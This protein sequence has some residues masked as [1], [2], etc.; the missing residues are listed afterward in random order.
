M[1]APRP[2]VPL[3]LTAVLLVLGMLLAGCG[4]SDTPEDSP[5]QVL[6]AAKKQLDTTSGVRIGLSTPKLPTGVDGLLSATGIG[7]HAPAFQ[8]TIK[9]AA[10]GFTA[11][12]DVVAVDG[13]VHAKLPFTKRFTVIDPADYGAPDPASL[14]DPEDGL[15]SLLTSATGM[16]SDGEVRE[17]KTV[18]RSY[19]GTVPGRSVAAVIPSATPGATFGATF[20]V[21]ARDR[22]S[23][24]VLTGPFYP[25]SGDVTYTITFDQYDT[26]KDIAAP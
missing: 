13:E 3:P 4:G 12:A 18:L 26:E 23:K 19:T 2:R 17:G 5:T 10:K 20:T 14:L 11:D 15:S 8:G 22:L 24:A 7:T 9:V 6:A 1:S 16:K 25:E 21:G